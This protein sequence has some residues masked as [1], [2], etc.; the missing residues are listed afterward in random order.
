MTNFDSVNLLIDYSTTD[1]TLNG[2]YEITIKGSLDDT[3]LTLK[4]ATF[5]FYL[6]EIVAQPVIKMT[7]ELS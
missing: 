1:K 2:V 5:K 7:A 4:T 6:F 3:I